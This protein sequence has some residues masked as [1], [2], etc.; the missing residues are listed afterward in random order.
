[1]LLLPVAENK[2]YVVGMSSD[3]TMLVPNL[4]KISQKIE[5]GIHTWTAQ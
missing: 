4:M 2:N 5:R 1:M 3:G